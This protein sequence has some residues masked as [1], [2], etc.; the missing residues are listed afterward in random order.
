VEG[1]L[2][3]DAKPVGELLAG[4]LEDNTAVVLGDGVVNRRNETTDRGSLLGRVVVDIETDDHA[5]LHGDVDT[6]ELATE[7]DVHLEDDLGDGRLDNLLVLHR[8]DRKKKVCV[9][10][11]IW[12]PK[13]KKILEEDALGDDAILAGAVLFDGVVTILLGVGE[14]CDDDLGNAG[15]VVGLDG[16][17]KVLRAVALE[18]A[19]LGLGDLDTKGTAALLQE[20]G[21]VLG[22]LAV[23]LREDDEPV[24]VGDGL[25]KLDRLEVA[26]PL[27]Y[28]RF[29]CF[30]WTKE[31]HDLKNHCVPWAGA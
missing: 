24:G 11:W 1:L 15:L 4:A 25:Q 27:G 20:L 8:P 6:P 21:Q 5:L 7:F 28:G 10:Y 29:V 31:F 14:E 19:H 17:D 23:T 3:A 16:L 9:R 30:S 26:R 13:K 18:G 2:E 22:L 12:G